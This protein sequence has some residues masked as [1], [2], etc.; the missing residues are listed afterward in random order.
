MNFTDK[1]NAM[2]KETDRFHMG[3][4]RDK[5]REELAELFDELNN[6][7]FDWGRATDEIADVLIMIERMLLSPRR[8][9]VVEKKITAKLERTKERIDSGYYGRTDK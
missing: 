2:L 3:K 5:C 8:R 7:L 4:V 9:S 6:E 1:Q